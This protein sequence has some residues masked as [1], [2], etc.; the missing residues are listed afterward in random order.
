M[1]NDLITFKSSVQFDWNQ[2][3]DQV[4]TLN[5][6]GNNLDNIGN[7]GLSFSL[8]KN[9]TFASGVNFSLEEA[10]LNRTAIISSLNITI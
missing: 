1:I 5:E 6:F 4:G 3:G 10:S 7:L 2:V 9:M 8:N